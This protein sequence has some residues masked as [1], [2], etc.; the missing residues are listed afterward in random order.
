MRKQRARTE[1]ALPNFSLHRQGRN[2][3]KRRGRHHQPHSY[4]ERDLGAQVELEAIGLCP[5][6]RT[7]LA[8]LS[9]RYATNTAASSLEILEHS[10]R[11]KTHLLAKALGYDRDVDEGKEL[12]RV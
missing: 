6:R 3:R 11:L 1:N 7:R 9:E 10:C 2:S 8:T 5:P 4:L 12:M